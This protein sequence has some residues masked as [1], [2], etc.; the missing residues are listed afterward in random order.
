MTPKVWKVSNQ[1]L[2]KL[3]GGP[4][5][6]L[7]IPHF[8]PGLFL[9][10]QECGRAACCWQMKESAPAGK[11]QSTV[12]PSDLAPLVPWT[13]VLSNWAPGTGSHT[14]QSGSQLEQKRTQP[15]LWKLAKTG[16]HVMWK[17]GVPYLS[18]PWECRTGYFWK[19][20]WELLLQTRNKSK[21]ALW[22]TAAF[23]WSASLGISKI[24]TLHL[25][26]LPWGLGFVSAH[27][28]LEIIVETQL[29][30]TG[31]SV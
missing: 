5:W 19:L 4:W 30:I 6:G 10:P 2:L 17:W 20:G 9:L 21:W 23:Y 16:T 29:D 26:L 12:V 22:F 13:G 1:S 25:H 15:A 3:P 27:G 28:F 14:S 7:A 8:F 11:A 31:A 18:E 24:A